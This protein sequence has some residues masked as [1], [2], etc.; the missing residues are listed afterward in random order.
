VTRT[1]AVK[2]TVT[3]ELGDAGGWITV[4]V[5]V[6]PNLLDNDGRRLVGSILRTML[7]LALPEKAAGT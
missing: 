7:E 1:N 3:V 2:A 4:D 6:H 5:D